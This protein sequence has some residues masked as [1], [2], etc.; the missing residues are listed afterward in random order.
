MLELDELVYLGEAEVYDAWNTPPKVLPKKILIVRDAYADDHIYRTP[1]LHPTRH[2]WVSLALPTANEMG[3][4]LSEY[5][6]APPTSEHDLARCLS[7]IEDFERGITVTQYHTWYKDFMA[8]VEN[9][10]KGWLRDYIR[11]YMS[12]AAQAVAYSM[13]KKIPEAQ[14]SPL[15]PLPFF[16]FIEQHIDNK[17]SLKSTK[18]PKGRGDQDEQ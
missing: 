7:L 13:Y 14:V 5:I 8:P 6:T 16:L 2:E 18:T 9:A 10:V 12:D 17:E 4:Y 11:S 3:R 1:Y 15:G